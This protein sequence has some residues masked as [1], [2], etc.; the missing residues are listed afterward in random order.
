MPGELYA[1]DPQHLK[2]PLTSVGV[3]DPC[4]SNNNGTSLVN[5]TLLCSPYPRKNA[6]A[7][8]LKNALWN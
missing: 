5:G 3:T 7:F 1:I 8:G 4:S 2:L 6:A